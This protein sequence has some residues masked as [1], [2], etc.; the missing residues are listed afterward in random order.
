MATPKTYV[1]YEQLTSN[2]QKKKK[3]GWFE[4]HTQNLELVV[5]N[6]DKERKKQKS[7]A[8]EMC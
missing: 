2:S 3:E 8:Q 4:I 6:K 1:I 7:S 5:P